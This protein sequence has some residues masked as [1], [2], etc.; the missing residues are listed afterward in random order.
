MNSS[1][2]PPAYMCAPPVPPNHAPGDL[3][4]E[5]LDALHGAVR[6]MSAR[7]AV[8]VARQDPVVTTSEAAQ[9]LG[10]TRPA[11]IKVLA[12]GGIPF[13]Q[14]GRRRYLRLADVLAYQG[15]ARRDSERAAA[16]SAE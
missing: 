5:V 11:L 8:T 7:T 2:A 1:F 9:V 3:S 6:A 13:E 15:R 10:M 14:P 16:S 4:A 12:A